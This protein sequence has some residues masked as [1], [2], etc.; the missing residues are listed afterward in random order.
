MSFAEQASRMAEILPL[1][2]SLTSF[3]ITRLI[4]RTDADIFPP[5]PAAAFREMDRRVARENRTIVLEEIVQLDGVAHTYLSVKSPLRDQQGRGY[6][7]LGISTDISEQKQTQQALIASERKYR[8]IFELSPLPKWVYDPQTLRFL[9]VNQAAQTQYGYTEAEFLRMTLR[10]LH[11]PEDIAGL[12]ADVAM[13]RTEAEFNRGEHRHRRKDGSQLEVI[14]YVHDIEFDGRGARMVVAQDISERKRSEQKVHEQLARLDLLHRITRATGERQ[15]LRSIFQAV[16][17]GMENEMPID[18]CCLCLYDENTEKI[19]ITSIGSRSDLLAASIGLAEQTRLDV[20]QNGLTRCLQGQLIYEPDLEGIRLPFPE[21]LARGGMR[22]LVATPMLV[23]SK[24]FGVL[25]AARRVRHGFSSGDCEFLRQLA[26]HI[27]LATHQ[28]RLYEALQRAYDDLRQ[29]QQIV[30]QQE[31]LRALGQMAS[32]IAHDI[33]NAISPVTLY[34]ESLLETETTLNERTRGYLEIIQHAVGDVAATVARMREFYRQG[35][36]Q[37]TLTPVA[38]NDLVSQVTSLTRAR[39]HDMPQQ[40]GHVITLQLDLAAGLPPIL[41]VESEIREALTNLILNAVDAMPE[42]GLLT[43][44]TYCRTAAAVAP[45]P[46]S[47]Q[48]EV[49]DTGV[50]M[51][52]ETRRHCLEPFFTTKGERGTG[53]GLAMVYGVVQRHNA[54]IEIESALGRG[55]TVH[56]QFAPFRPDGET[57]P[58]PADGVVSNVRWRLLIVDDDPLLLKSLRDLLERDGHVVTTAGDGQ[59]GIDTFLAP[60]A[61]GARFDIVITDLG[62]PYVDGRTVAAAVKTSS[63]ETPV[64]LL[65][66]WGQRLVSEGDIPLHVDLVLSKP[67][68]LRELRSALARCWRARRP[69]AAAEKGAKA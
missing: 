6:G 57:P 25:V 67:P 63:P 39:W 56:L 55:T 24:V 13:R 51:D 60:G 68:R 52:E 42:G 32:G 26:E 2:D 9:A 69:S 46:L 16:I 27:A 35:E 43:V 10:D 49:T 3:G 59:A 65:T 11:L 33:N 58:Q 17:G 62:M 5:E 23:E 21:R 40:R 29:T 19:E 53:L 48:L 66:G 20:N 34:V 30:L 41:G 50:G 12:E 1:P 8:R 37:M 64:I 14:I 38:L 31:R 15:D 61:G 22:S 44:R 47:V 18:F 36:P 28:G 7:V 45:D 54:E 4:G